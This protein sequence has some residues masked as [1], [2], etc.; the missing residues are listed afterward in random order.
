MNT[1][2]KRVFVSTD[3]TGTIVSEIVDLN[4][5]EHL[6][7]HAVWTGA[8]TG[9]LHFEVSGQIGT[10]TVWEIFDTA[11]VAGAGSQYWIDR[12]VPYR[13]AR[14]RYQPTGGTGTIDADAI[15]K[16]DI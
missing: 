4:N 14:L 2:A 3:M 8:P 5:M 1:I 9:D 6:G 11:S 7:I 12:N 15:S 16:G 10:P 13:W